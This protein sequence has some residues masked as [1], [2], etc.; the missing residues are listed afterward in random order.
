MLSFQMQKPGASLQR[1]QNVPYTLSAVTDLL[2]QQAVG[3]R[4]PFNQSV[5]HSAPKS[6]ETGAELQDLAGR[7]HLPN[8]IAW[9]S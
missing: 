8:A 5:W 6:Q 1:P 4:T 7:C 9:G 2:G 3:S